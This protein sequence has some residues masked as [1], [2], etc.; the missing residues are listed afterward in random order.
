MPMNTERI[1]WSDRL[2]QR[3]LT[4]ADLNGWLPAD[5]DD[6]RIDYAAGYE[7]A[8]ELVEVHPHLLEV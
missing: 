6:D 2:V 3:I 8:Q 7:I 4:V 5:L 1:E